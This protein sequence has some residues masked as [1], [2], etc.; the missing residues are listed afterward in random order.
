MTIEYK[1]KLLNEK[2]AISSINSML[3]SINSLFA[4]VGWSECMVKNYKVQREVFCTK[5]KELSK[6]EYMRLVNTAQRRG[7]VRLYLL[8]QTICA[9]GM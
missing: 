6:E 5:E 2:Y 4:F 8:L 3:A 1:Q 9:T 7:N